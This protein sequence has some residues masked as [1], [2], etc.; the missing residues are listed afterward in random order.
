MI[1]TGAPVNLVCPAPTIWS[2]CGRI[3]IMGKSFAFVETPFLHCLFYTDKDLCSLGF[4]FEHEVVFICLKPFAKSAA[5]K[6]SAYPR[7]THNPVNPEPSN[8]VNQSTTL[9]NSFQ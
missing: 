9:S 2:W 1:V 3:F 7:K 6:Q 4:P 8:Q 5:R